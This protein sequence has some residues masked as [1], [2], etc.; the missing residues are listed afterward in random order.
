MNQ[1][2]NEHKDHLAGIIHLLSM[3]QSLTFSQIH[4]YYPELKTDILKSL[5]MRLAKEGRLSYLPDSDL[6][7]YN[8]NCKRKSS[9]I[10]AFWVLLDFMPDVTYHS[11]SDFPVAL[12]FYTDADAYDVIHIPTEKELLINHAFSHQLADVSKRIIIIDH[13]NQIPLIKI[14]NVTA[15]CTINK[16]GKVQYY[17]KQGVNDT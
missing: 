14:P 9:T 1:K 16:L 2:Q 13:P 11:I 4:R 6:L 7:L 3:Y 10:A 5:I 17:K 12:T 8:K 15:Y